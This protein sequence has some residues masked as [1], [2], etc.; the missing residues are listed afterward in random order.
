MKFQKGEKLIDG[1]EVKELRRI[2]TYDSDN[3]E[4]GWLVDILRSEDP[5]KKDGKN[6]SQIYVTT[7]KP[8]MV[9]GFH[10]HKKKVDL[11]FVVA[12]TVKLV[13]VDDRDGSP[14]IGSVN[15]FLMGEDGR[16]IIVRVPQNVKHALKNV[17]DEMAYVMNYMNPP[18]DPKDPDDYAWEGYEI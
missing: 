1:V 14:S 7:A 16:N 15:E 10:W 5:I 11:F 8:G 2:A 12:G 4:N 9:K 3:N 17:G 13:L 6:F 18:F